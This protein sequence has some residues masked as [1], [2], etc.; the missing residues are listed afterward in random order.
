MSP[1]FGCGAETRDRAQAEERERVIEAQRELQRL[2]LYQGPIDGQL[3]PI[4]RGAIQAFQRRVGKSPTGM[5]TAQ[6][7][8]E[9]RRSEVPSSSGT[10]RNS[11]GSAMGAEADA[12]QRREAEVRAL[13]EAD[14]RQRREAEVRALAEADARQRQEAEVRARAEADARQRQ[15]GRGTAGAEAELRAR[16]EVEIRQRIETEARQREEAEIR[17]REEAERGARREAMLQVTGRRV[18]LVIGNGD[19]RHGV[20]L[21]NPVNDARRIASMLDDIGFEVILGLDLDR[22]DMEQKIQEFGNRLDGARLGLLFYAG[23]GMQVVGENYLIPVD[24]KLERERDLPFETI[25]MGQILRTMESSAA[26]NLVFLDACRD[27]PLARSLA[28]SLGT[29]STAVGQGLA[30]IQSGLGTFV[31]YA[32]QPGNVALDGGGANSP[33]TEALAHHLATPGVDIG[34]AM[35][36]VREAVVASTSGR[37]VPWDHS[38]LTGEV[39]LRPTLASESVTRPATG[40]PPSPAANAASAF[41][42][43]ALF[44]QSAIAS[45]HRADLEAYLLAFPNGIFSPLARG[46]LSR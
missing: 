36:R 41:D 26:A 33:F 11:G 15:E 25:A 46:R 19:Y 38:S 23:H 31:A 12:R 8:D 9:L 37:Q 18:A 44:W 4:T 14:A 40:F 43:E 5:V 10:D 1:K 28:R 27:N 39:V 34:M 24:A 17:A 35:R 42:R 45:G 13:A 2:Q 16:I 20:P 6:V 21:R 30:Q 32:T 7:V 22:R 3:G 29:R